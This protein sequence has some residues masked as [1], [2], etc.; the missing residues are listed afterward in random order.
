MNQQ[1]ISMQTLAVTPGALAELLQMLAAGEIN[2]NTAKRV[3]AEMLAGNDSAAQ[4]V[5]RQG[6]RQISDQGQVAEL[7]AA[8][9]AD[10]PEPLKDYLEGKEQLKQYFFGQVMRAAGGKANPQVVQAELERQLSS[11]KKK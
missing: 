4:I 10:N 1:G 6:L 11:L 3:L 7:V 9:L 5:E 2:Q 8:A